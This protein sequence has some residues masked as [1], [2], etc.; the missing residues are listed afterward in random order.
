MDFFFDGLIIIDAVKQSAFLIL[1][2]ETGLY[3]RISLQAVPTQTFWKAYRHIN[4]CY[5][6]QDIITENRQST[7]PCTTDVYR[8]SAIYLIE[9]EN[10][11]EWDL[12]PV[13]KFHTKWSL[14]SILSTQIWLQI[15]GKNQTTFRQA[16]FHRLQADFML[17]TTR[18]W[19]SHGLG[20]VAWNFHCCL[21]PRADVSSGKKRQEEKQ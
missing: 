13:L 17:L 21:P 7:Q 14:D 1:R 9:K 8:K 5:N 6:V 10:A 19:K 16:T 20:K 18:Y 4:I 11:M 2:S 12:P 3:Q 15:W